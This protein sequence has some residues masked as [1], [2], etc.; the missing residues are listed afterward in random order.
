MSIAL[1]Q[2]V[3]SLSDAI[4]AL[5]ERLK[6]AEARLS[7]LESGYTDQQQPLDLPPKR[8]GRPPKNEN[9]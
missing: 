7:S 8:R 2:K 5:T 3:K 6:A 9:V 4:E 1:V